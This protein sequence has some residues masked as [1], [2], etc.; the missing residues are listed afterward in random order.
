MKSTKKS[1]KWGGVQAF[2]EKSAKKLW[3]ALSLFLHSSALLLHQQIAIHH[4]QEDILLGSGDFTDLRNVIFLTGSR[5]LKQ[6][7]SSSDSHN[8]M[9]QTQYQ[10]S[11][12]GVHIPG[13]GE[14]GGC[15]PH[16]KEFHGRRQC[17]SFQK[18]E[19]RG[20]RPF[21]KEQDHL[22]R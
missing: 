18:E 1:G 22:Q 14:P 4:E 12:E 10:H 11:E 7:K 2:A 9:K 5:K 13:A 21:Q 20:S 6:T 16:Y 17:G 15:H 3:P 8:H 19:V